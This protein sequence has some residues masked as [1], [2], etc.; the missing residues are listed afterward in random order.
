MPDAPRLTVAF[1]MFV[2]QYDPERPTDLRQMT[3]GIGG[4]RAEAPPTV[5]LTL[6]VGLWNKG[7]PGRVSCRIG[8]VRPGE[9]VQYIGEGD[10]TVADPGEM[11]VLPLKLTFTFDRP[12]TYWLIGE[13]DGRP[14]VEV[15]FTV[16][17][18]APPGQIES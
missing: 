18:D 16:S 9:N 4:W 8:V 12:G 6:A 10:T 1:A 15:P 11:V 3:T 2:Q 17:A 7:G 5:P 13:F 14:L